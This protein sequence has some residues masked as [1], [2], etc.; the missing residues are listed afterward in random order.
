VTLARD[1]LDLARWAPSGDNS[2]PW[3]FR[4]HSEREFDILGYDTRASVVYD[5]D[6]CASELSHGILLET[7]RIAASRFGCRAR[8]A[9]HRSAV[10]ERVYRVVLEAEP[11]LQ[12]H[13]L[14]AFIERRTVQRRPMRPRRLRPDERGALQNAAKPFGAVWFE[15]AAERHRVACLCASN[16]WIRLTIPEAYA[17]H[18][19]VIEWHA[20]T[21]EER[22][23][24]A[25]LGADPFLL[26]VMRRAMSS[27]ERLD[28]FNRI[29][30]TV[31]PRLELD[32]LPVLCS[33]A[34]VALIAPEAASSLADRVEAGAAVQRLWLTATALGL[35]MQPLYTPLVFARYASEGR[36]FTKRARGQAAAI[37]I[38]AKLRTLLGEQDVRRAVWLARIGPARDVPGRSMRHPLSRLIVE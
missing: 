35:Q 19:A 13:A 34:Q 8:I 32:Y 10:P 20:T 26:A 37:G 31:L 36:A 22:L 18:R 33:S 16:A 9:I 25:S 11:Q 30:G 1:V 6:G 3:R 28:R 14:C 2:Q 4:I 17:V 24:D 15:S 21:S 23:P 12:E 29:F 27:W 5:L 7:I 38:L